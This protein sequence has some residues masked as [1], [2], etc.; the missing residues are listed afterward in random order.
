MNDGAESAAFSGLFRQA[1]L[2]LRREIDGAAASPGVG[3]GPAYVVDRRRVHVLHRHIERDLVEA[4]IERLHEALR[5]C[6]QQIEVVKS[7]LRTVSTA[8]S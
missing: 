6:R 3:I 8:R 1:D 7:H 2:G 4:E 5:A